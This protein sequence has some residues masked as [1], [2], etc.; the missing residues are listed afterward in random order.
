LLLKFLEQAVAGD[1]LT[2]ARWT[3]LHVA[4]GDMELALLHSA[5]MARNALRMP[6]ILFISVSNTS[7]ALS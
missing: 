5:V 1:D 2:A 6:V 3:F 4:T 7:N